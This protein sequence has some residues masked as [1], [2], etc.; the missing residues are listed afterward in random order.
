MEVAYAS[1]TS[2]HYYYTAVRYTPYDRSVL[3]Q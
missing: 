2:V 3:A 1:E